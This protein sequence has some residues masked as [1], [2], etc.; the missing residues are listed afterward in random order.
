MAFVF[1]TLGY[2]KKLREAGVEPTVA[3]AHAEAAGDF[4]MFVTKTDLAATRQH[5]EQELQ[6]LEQPIQHQTLRLT[7][8]LGGI[9]VAGIGVL[10]ALQCLI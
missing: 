7:L 9:M 5:L 4:V 3:E 1:D 6:H 10:A 8:R 2:A